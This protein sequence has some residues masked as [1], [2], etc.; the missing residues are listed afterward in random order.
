MEGT[1]GETG[2]EGEVASNATNVED[3][4]AVEGRKM[5]TETNPEQGATGSNAAAVQPVTKKAKITEDNS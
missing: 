1:E 4:D 2:V 3:D 5:K